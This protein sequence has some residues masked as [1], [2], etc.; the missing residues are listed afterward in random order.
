[1]RRVRQSVWRKGEEQEKTHIYPILIVSDY[2]FVKGVL[3][4]P[5]YSNNAIFT[6]YL[7]SKFLYMVF[8]DF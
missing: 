2:F 4:V 5:T 6:A 8:P 7:Y 1:M 3:R